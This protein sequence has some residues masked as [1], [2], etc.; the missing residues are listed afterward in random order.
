M[1]V[2]GRGDCLAGDRVVGDGVDADDQHVDLD[3]W[4]YPN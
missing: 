2:D 4:K 3:G 1:V